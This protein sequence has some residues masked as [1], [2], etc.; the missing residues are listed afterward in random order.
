MLNQIKRTFL[1]GFVT[2]L[3]VT[4]NAQP[5]L[6]EKVEATPDG[7]TIPYEKYKMPNGLTIMICED[8][9]DPVATVMVTYKVGANRETPGI[10]GFAHFFEHMM[11]QGSKHVAD[12]EQFKIISEAGGDMNGNTTEDRT[13]Y[14]DNIPSNQVEVALWCE[15]DRMGYLL[16]SLT[17][18][19]FEGQR[20][21]VK[22]EKFQNVINQPYGLSGEVGNQNLYPYGHPYSWPVIGYVEDLNRASLQD[23]KNFFIRWYGPNNAILT[24]AGDVDPKQILVWA[25]KYFGKIKSGPEVKKIKVA[26]ISLPEN[27]YASYSDKIY[28]P[29]SFMTYPTVP[30]FHRDEPA[31][32]ILGNIM[33][34]GNNSIM[35]KKFVKTEKAA[36]AGAYNRGLELAGEFNLY[37]I[38]YFSDEAVRSTA[39]YEKM[40]KEIDEQV[41]QT[42]DEFEKT[43]I[44]DEAF[45][46]VKAQREAGI[47]SGVESTY[48]KAVHLSQWEWIL[49]KKYT[50]KDELDRYAKV[51][52]DDVVRVF[53]K[54]IKSSGAGVVNVYPLISDTDSVRCLYPYEGMQF[55]QDPEYVNLSFTPLA[56]AKE[57]FKKPLGTS[58][59]IPKIPDYTTK[60]FDNGLKLIATRTTETPTVQ[61]NIQMEGGDLLIANEDLKKNGI[62]EITANMM[63]E[64]TQSKTPE[65]FSAALDRLG[66]SVF[67]GAGKTGTYVSMSCLKKNL[68]ATLKLMEE[69]LYTPRFDEK[70]FKRVKKQMKENAVSNKFNSDFMASAASA[71]ILYGNTIWGLSPT[72]KNYD[73]MEL[74]DVKSYY[75]KYYSPSVSRVVIVGDIDENEIFSKLDFLKNWKDKKVVINPPPMVAQQVE[76]TIFL[77]DKAGAASSIINV[78]QPSIKYDGPTGDSYKNSVANFMLGGTFSSRLN[79]DLREDKGY[80]YGIYSYFS[81]NEFGGNMVI[82]TSVKRK[83][84]GASLAEIM[85]VTKNYIEKGI[86]DEDVTFTKNSYLNGQAGNY[87]TNSAKA[88]FLGY[89]LKYNVNKDYPLKQAELLKSMTKDD[90]N[91]QIKSA[92]DP[93]KMIFV[94]V[95]DKYAVKKQMNEQ[96]KQVK[97]FNEKLNAKK[98]KEFKMDF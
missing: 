12:D 40:F 63:G 60:V 76:P 41:K 52:K 26:P 14:Y 81:G 28:L 66:S 53:N 58:P 74:A 36:A 61:L 10:S 25:D 20:D 22:N 77:I 82:G 1:A 5:V 65:E 11:F 94:I 6:I 47:L 54:Y 62:A 48:E 30:W 67:V 75:E 80:T 13:Q 44:T 23:V 69:C 59:K 32:E 95:G 29:A 38:P 55:K 93:S 64:G 72:K 7:L 4:A 97:D 86:T 89:L 46:R 39:M 21:A 87:E 57:D 17:S 33:G 43:G 50:L 91:K 19:K 34:G 2:L 68:D 92:Y 90:F 70:D 88:G 15:A 3:Y 42:L 79:M 45:Q 84:S 56:D 8:H 98:L 18:K 96:G 35:Y 78:S 31:L 37:I 71:N 51:T 83:A 27:K 9:S 16:D 73:K 24:V 85:K 49:G